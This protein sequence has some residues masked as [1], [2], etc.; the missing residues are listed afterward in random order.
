ML[1]VQVL[2]FVGIPVAG[3][4][5]VKLIRHDN[6]KSI[7]KNQPTRLTPLEDG[8]AIL[9]ASIMWPLAVAGFIFCYL[10]GFLGGLARPS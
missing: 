9:L 3:Y 4:V 8:M 7:R 6:A 5:A 2:Y 10:I 1:W